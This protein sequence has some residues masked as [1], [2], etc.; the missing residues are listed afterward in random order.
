MFA[1]GIATGAAFNYPTGIAVHP[2]GALFVADRV[3]NRI[4]RI[5]PNLTVTTFAGR[6]GV[7]PSYA[8]GA[9]TNA[10]FNDPCG[11]ALDGDGNLFVADRQ[12]NRIRR[13]DPGGVVSLFVGS[14][15]YAFSNGAGSGASFQYPSGLAVD[16]AGALL[17]ADTFNH[18]I[19][20]VTPVGVVTVLAGNGTGAGGGGGLCQRCGR[21]RCLPATICTRV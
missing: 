1:D 6:G 2:G 7:A 11:V 4:R 19:R 21:R 10:L 15:A 13:V 17:V 9:G 20:R 8:E 14:G 3:G 16:G 5:A 12:N 18:L